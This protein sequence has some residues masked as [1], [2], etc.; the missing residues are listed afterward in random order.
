MDTFL[1]IASRREVRSYSGEPIS[2]EVV[3]TILEAG[4]VAGS[5]VNRQPWRFVVVRSRQLLDDLATTV[6][7]P[8]NL[9]GAELFVAIVVGDGRIQTFDAGRAAQNM[10]LAGWNAG[11]GSCPNGFQDDGRAAK[12][13]GLD[14][15]S[16][17]FV[18]LSFG[19]PARPRRP[20]QRTAE[21]W[22]TRAKRLPLDELVLAWL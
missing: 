19:Y 1:A 10:M 3:H 17:L 9:L 18:G 5:G 7:A 2:D 16:S 20:E 15:P 11:V 8:H 12:L 22:L 14:D 13:L 6:Y 4:R 21:A